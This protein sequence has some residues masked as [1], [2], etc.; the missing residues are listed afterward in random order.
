MG[1][2]EGQSEKPKEPL[3]MMMM[4]MKTIIQMHA[5]PVE[6][7]N[8]KR[9]NMRVMVTSEGKEGSDSKDGHSR[10]YIKL[11]LCRKKGCG[12]CLSQKHFLQTIDIRPSYG[13]LQ[14]RQIPSVAAFYG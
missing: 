4:M 1:R 3:M 14:R 10:L 5:F 2:E 9:Q 7:P 12:P 6:N 11:Q 13:N 8:A